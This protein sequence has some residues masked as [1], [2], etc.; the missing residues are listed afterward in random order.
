MI[1]NCQMKKLSLREV[2]PLPENTQLQ[3]CVMLEFEPPHDHR[4][5]VLTTEPQ[6]PSGIRD[7][8]MNGV[9]L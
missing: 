4:M 9:Q 5:R 8:R 1:P 3:R 7:L 2:E 6:V